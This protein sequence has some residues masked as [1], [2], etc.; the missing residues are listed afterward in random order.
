MKRRVYRGTFDQER[1]DRWTAFCRSIES[2]VL[3]DLAGRITSEPMHVP[4]GADGSRTFLT[5]D[6]YEAL[7]AEAAR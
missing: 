4:K 1:F 2:G 5:P 7:R 3:I 6:Q